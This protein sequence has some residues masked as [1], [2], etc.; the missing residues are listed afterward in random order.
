MSASSAHLPSVRHCEIRRHTADGALASGMGQVSAIRAGSS[1]CRSKSVPA[2]GASLAANDC[3]VC[4]T[5]CGLSCRWRCKLACFAHR[6]SIIRPMSSN[7]TPPNSDDDWQV[8]DQIAGQWEDEAD[9]SARRTT[10]RR[11]R[12]ARPAPSASR[13][14]LS[15]PAATPLL[16]IGGV[17]LL[18]MCGLACFALMLFLLGGQDSIIDRFTRGEAK[19]TQRQA[20]RFQ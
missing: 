17:A 5:A 1:P 4:S 11:P 13:S 18:G 20:C 15:D 14:L 12:R 16:V 19:A 10:A 3:S 2:S 8:E 9:R 6:R 7:P